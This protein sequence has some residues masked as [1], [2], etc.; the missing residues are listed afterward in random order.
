MEKIES[1]KTAKGK[2]KLYRG[3]LF[4][5]SYND[6]LTA[7]QNAPKK[8]GAYNLIGKDDYVKSWQV[9]HGKEYFPE[10]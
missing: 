1:E 10:Y 6:V 7:L 4:L 3:F 8:D 5:A 2:Y 9:L